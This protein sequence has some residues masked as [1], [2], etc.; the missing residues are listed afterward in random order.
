MIVEPLA[1]RPPTDEAIDCDWIVVAESPKR[2]VREGS[3]SVVVGPIP[4]DRPSTVAMADAPVAASDHCNCL[5]GVDVSASAARSGVARA[6]TSAR[7]WT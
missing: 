7:P 5:S 1:L 6:T 2:L 4:T 3:I